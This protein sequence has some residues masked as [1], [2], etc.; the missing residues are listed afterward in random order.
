[1]NTATE[2]QMFS[3]WEHFK[4]A[5]DLALVLGSDHPKVK[6]LTNEA[7]KLIDRIKTPT[8]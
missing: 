4:A 7:N 3:Y 8:P 6:L 1:M 5:R 2:I